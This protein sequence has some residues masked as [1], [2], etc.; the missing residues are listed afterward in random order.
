MGGLSMKN[1]CKKGYPMT[2]CRWE[3]LSEHLVKVLKV[4]ST[5][6]ETPDP[7][8]MLWECYQTM[9]H[10]LKWMQD[11]KIRDIAKEIR[12]LKKYRFARCDCTVWLNIDR[13]I[14]SL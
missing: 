2:E 3:Q 13:D 8:Y 6:P 10:T 14:K 5:N 7:Q 12:I 4:D 9:K 1:K 11:H